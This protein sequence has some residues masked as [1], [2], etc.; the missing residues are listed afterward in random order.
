MTAANDIP[1]VL[2]AGMD[3]TGVLLADLKG[4]LSP[5]RR[6]EVVSYPADPTLG[7]EALTAI[8]MQRL[9]NR[10][11]VVLGESFS[12]PI[13]I[14]IAASEPQ[15]VA[16]LVLASSF[17]RSP[18]P[19]VVAP[20]AK[21]LDLHWLPR[22]AIEAALLGGGGTPALKAS[23]HRVLVSLPREVIRRR[24]AEVAGVDKRERLR[25]VAC[26]ILCLVGSRDRLA[27]RRCA[28]QIA[29]A[30]PRCTIRVLGAPHMLL[31]THAEAAAHAIHQFCE[32]VG[33]A[34]RGAT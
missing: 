11:Y 34:D 10:R 31:E 28:E 6:V 23:L 7:Y 33:G 18:L 30:H 26:P 19:A 13:A 20:L 27:G 3:G 1:I 2:L 21:R 16:G 24:V 32:R 12:G 4:W 14:E 15:R 22:W 8:A 5:Q 17:A 9:P 25:R 29:Q